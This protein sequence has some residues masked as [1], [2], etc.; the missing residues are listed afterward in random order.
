MPASHEMVSSEEESQGAD[1]LLEAFLASEIELLAPDI[2]LLEAANTL[3]KQSIL[4]KQL[5]PEKARSIFR[6]FLTLPLSLHESNAWTSQALKMSVELRHPIY[7]YSVLRSRERKRLRVHY[8]RSSPVEK[9][10][11]SLLFFVRLLSTISL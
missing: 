8:C 9:L 1:S 7:D 3:W 6:D 11:G 2:L 4:L 10:A 5:R